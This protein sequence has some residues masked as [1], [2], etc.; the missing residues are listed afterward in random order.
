M[1]WLVSPSA[2][3]ALSLEYKLK[4]RR[5]RGYGRVADFVNDPFCLRLGGTHEGRV[6]AA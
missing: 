3:D 2:N 6:K 5:A 4:N 1:E